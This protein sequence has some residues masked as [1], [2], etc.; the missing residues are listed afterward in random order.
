MVMI[1]VLD[2]YGL[3]EVWFSVFGV[4]VKFVLGWLVVLMFVFIMGIFVGLFLL[5]IL[6]VDIK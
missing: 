6:K 5:L 4:M 1:Y 2:F 3:F